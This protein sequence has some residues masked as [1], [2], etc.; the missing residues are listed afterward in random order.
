M[1]SHE[2]PTFSPEPL[3]HHQAI[4]RELGLYA[5]ELKFSDARGGHMAYRRLFTE[6]PDG[7]VYFVKGHDGSLFTEDVRSEHARQYLKKEHMLFTYLQESGYLQVP[8]ISRLIDENYLLIEGLPSEKGW[9]WR[10]PKDNPDLFDRYVQDTLESFDALQAVPL[11]PEHYFFPKR[12]MK[13]FIE[14][15]WENLSQNQLQKIGYAA[16]GL[17]AQLY[18]ETEQVLDEALGRLPELV[19]QGKALYDVAQPLYLTHHDAR[20]ANIAWHPSLGTKNIDLSWMDVGWKNADA[21]M[22]LIDLAKAGHDVTPYIS[23]HFSPEH[24]L[25]LMGHWFG[26]CA[27]PTRDGST[28]VRLHQLAS[29]LTAYQLL[30]SERYI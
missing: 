12:I 30:S 9:Y 16:Q 6:T 2:T 28:T 24:A 18:P 15:G 3:P 23:S 25:L 19:E 8:D 13:V 14:E 10:A 29:A 5:E 26:R 27:E 7:E 20:Q 4:A 21:T 11:P 1:N 22:F 17:R